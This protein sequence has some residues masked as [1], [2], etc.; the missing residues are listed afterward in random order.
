MD[1]IK[2]LMVAILIA[3]T[4]F[5]VA[6]EFAII[7][8]R[9]SR[10][11]QL[12]SEKRR[13]ALAAK[14]VTSNLDEY[15]SACQLGITITALGLGWLGEPTIKHLLEPLFLK[16][17]FSPAIASTVSFIIAFAV[18]TFLH[19][20]IGEL[21][22]KTLAIQRAE[23]VSLLL[24][25]PIIYFYRVMY[26]FIWALNGSARLVTGLFGLHPASEHEVAH[27]EEELRLILSESYESGEINQRE[28]KYVNNI[29][30][31]DNRVAKEIMVPRTEVV[32]LYEDE[33]FETHIK[34]I[35]QE[36]YT[37]Y[38]VFGEDKDEIIGM[39]NVKDLFIRYMD[40]N[41]DEECSI[42]PYTRPVIEV[43]ENIPIHDL[44]LQ[45]QRRR[46]PLAV[47]YDE[48]GGT[49]GIV[50]LEDILEEIVGEIRDEYDEDEHPPIEHI[51]EGCKI[52]EGKVL[53]SEVNDLFGIH[54]IA[55]DVDTIGGWIMVQKQIVAEGD[56]IEKSGFSF[57]VLEKDMHQIKRV[58]IKKVEE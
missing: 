28:F 41:R 10:I 4:G 12:V 2:L 32:G 43:L 24:S 13:G 51:S 20:V 53:I 39:V 31:F 42:T 55:D 27:S 1:I 33:L 15:L 6:V 21:A 54:L 5:F 23:Q 36:K 56:V 49:A 3:L 48:Y 19:V 35:A 29:F 34:I 57:K 37:R 52:V 30:E 47:L 16:L 45:M 38:P 14:K 8:V 50:T 17:H 11:D 18:I 44:L 22:P 25:K 58:E 7:K 46:I 40:G 26:P 9:S